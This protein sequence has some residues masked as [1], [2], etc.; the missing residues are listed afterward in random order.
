[1]LKTHA[2]IGAAM[3]IM[4]VGLPTAYSQQQ[5][6]GQGAPGGSTLYSPSS[7]STNNNSLQ[8]ASGRTSDLAPDTRALAGAQDFSLGVPGVRR[9]FWQPFF[10]AMST[11]DTNALGTENVTGLTTWTSFWGGFGLL[12]SAGH[13]DLTLN[14]LTFGLTGDHG[15][16]S[17][18]LGQQ[19]QF[20]EKLSW[21]RTVVSFFDQL[22]YLP[23]TALG[24]GLPGA[25]TFAGDGVSLQPGLL[26]DQSI[27]TTFGQRISNSFV[28]E[29]DELL[30]PRSSLTFVGSYSLLR[31]LDNNFLNL[32]DAVFQAGYNH[33]INRKSTVALL[34][35]ISAFRY[36]NFNQSIDTHLVEVAYGRRVM[37]R[38]AFQLAAGPEVG[39]FRLPISA[40]GAALAAPTPTATARSSTKVYWTWDTSMFY[41]M[42]RTQFGLAYD[43]SLSGGAGVLAG[44]LSDQVSASIN[45]KYRRTLDAGLVLG[46]ARNQGLNVAAPT[47]AN[48]S[49]NYWFGGVN[50]SHPWGRSLNV[51]LN[52]RLQYQNSNSGFCVGIT[53]GQNFLRHT[54]SM[55]FG[56]RPRPMP[57]GL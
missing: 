28:T 57:I 29:V 17:N 4:F 55:G 8:S 1:M 50:F 34:Y 44:A 14:Y 13:S 41:Q 33:Q 53:C 25:Q 11:L 49:Y 42:G 2:R 5:S 54:L 26:L 36:D 12:R 15:N 48:Q 9:S 56:W 37:G 10:G 18:A 46:F 52:Y 7:P 47:P 20:A 24:T 22:S 27:L 21:H 51:F 45:S 38:L 19:L 39:V 3:A 43:H 35:R 32:S 16:T 23:E 40:S 30:T 6:T 31:F